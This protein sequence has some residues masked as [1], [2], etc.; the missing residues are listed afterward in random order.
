MPTPA[1]RACCRAWSANNYVD[2]TMNN[3]TIEVHQ[4]QNEGRASRLHT[5]ATSTAQQE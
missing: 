2:E 3:D 1:A 4:M 5:T